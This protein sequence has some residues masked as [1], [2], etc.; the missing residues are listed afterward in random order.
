MAGKGFNAWPPK[1]EA[2]V[3]DKTRGLTND[4]VV[5]VMTYA[6]DLYAWYAGSITADVYFCP[7][8]HGTYFG[9]FYIKDA[10]AV[11][12]PGY[13][14]DE[15]LTAT[16][17]RALVDERLGY[18]SAGGAARMRALATAQAPALSTDPD[19]SIVL[20]RTRISEALRGLIRST[21]PSQAELD[22]IRATVD[23]WSA[24]YGELDGANN[25][26]YATTYHEV[27][28]NVGG[29]WIT[30][31]QKARLQALRQQVMTVTYADGTTIDFSVTA[32][33][34]LYAA[35]IPAG[36]ADLLGWS[37]DAATDPLFTGP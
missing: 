33:H 27:F 4:E 5:A 1:A 17:G 32:K 28:N 23:Q 13:S 37:G 7:E 14:I 22:A 10:P 6:G 26:L 34:F 35:E 2:D 11:G 8:R 20:A 25:H 15:Q 36:S 19:A 21:P 30:D 3:R 29:A 24:I 18:V 12:H 31:A 16:V 9:S